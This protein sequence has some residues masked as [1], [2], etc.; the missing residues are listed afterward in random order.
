MVPCRCVQR[1]RS[2][3][4]LRDA[5]WQIDTK[6]SEQPFGLIVNRSGS[7]PP[8]RRYRLTSQNSEGHLSPTER[9]D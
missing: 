3:G 8:K 6:V 4:T 7:P 2:Y 9:Q 5:E 1:P